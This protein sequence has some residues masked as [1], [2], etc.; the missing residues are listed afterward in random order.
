MTDYPNM[1]NEILRLCRVHTSDAESLFEAVNESIREVSQ[2]MPW[3][4]PDYSLEESKTWCNS[5][6]EAWK[7]GEAYD[8]LIIENMNNTLLGVCGLNLINA[9]ERFAN[10]GY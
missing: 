5:R 8:F 10:L 3:C 1:K 4:K 7:N 6:D 9:E 2:W